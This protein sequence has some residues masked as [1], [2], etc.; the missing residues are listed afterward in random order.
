MTT[1][2]E[3]VK[4]IPGMGVRKLTLADQLPACEIVINAA[5]YDLK[6]I[7]KG[8]NVVDIGCGF[9]A[10]RKIVE[11]VGGKWTG[12]EP[13]EGGG[14]TVIADAENL[15][16][17]NNTFD[18]AIMDAVLEHIPN[19]SKA[20]T[21]VARVLK[22]GGVFIGYVAFMECFHEI[23]YSHLSFK[24][25]E[26]FSKINGMKLEKISG[27]KRFGIDY[28]KM[29]LFYPLPVKWIRPIRASMIRGIIR[30]K[31]RLAYLG[32]RMKRKLAHAEAKK[33]SGQYYQL[34]C[35]RQSVGFTYIIRKL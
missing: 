24:A 19:A 17:E 12:V 9:G 13:F 29:V 6:E 28:H 20:I 15:P 34:E 8:K 1:Q 25:L 14:H 11:S 2:Q 3:E 33:M 32:L 21:E 18:V 30:T 26:H 23:S 31:S 5:I 22:P 35:L 16:F 7:C 4:L 27:G 10:N